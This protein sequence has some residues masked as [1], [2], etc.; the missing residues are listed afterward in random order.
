MNIPEEPINPCNP[1]PCGPNA[2]C[3]ERN[4][5]GSCACLKDYFGDP[6]TGCRPECV[7]NTDCSRDKACVNNKC[8]DPCPGVCGF[9]AECHAYN[10]AP[11]CTCL[12]GYTGNPL[13]SCNEPPITPCKLLLKTSKSKYFIHKICSL[14]PPAERKNPCSPSP[15]GQYSQCREINNHA[16]CS[17]LNNYIGSPPNCRPECIVSSECAQNKACINEKCI[18]PCPGTCGINA[19]CTVINHNPI[20]SCSPGY[21]GDP[22]IK[23][24]EATSKH[25]LLLVNFFIFLYLSFACFIFI[26]TPLVPSS[27]P[28]VPS[29]CGPNSQCRVVGDSPACTCLPNYIGRPPN[30]RP[31]CV[32][33]AD[34]PGTLA[35]IN[36]KCSN[37]C[38][39]AC[40]I[41]T[42]CTVIKHSP[43]CK[44]ETG[45]TGDPFS[46]CSEIPR[47]KN[48]IF[49]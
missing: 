10:H 19:R 45:F 34:C 21:D 46:S 31:E 36:E 7:T 41:Q 38:K 28:C 8:K 14:V 15:C 24:I 20:C 18:D 26:E 2:V 22:F 16:V 3:K 44:C 33:N 30:C 39:G 17:C 35:C 27:I 9:N 1:S 40:G 13:V 25:D 29:P 43:V 32:I 47:C 48:A 6:Y 4:N 12:T 11:T 42:I 49:K 5:A 37:P 23:C